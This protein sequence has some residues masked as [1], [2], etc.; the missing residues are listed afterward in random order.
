M[1]E[2]FLKTLKK[3]FYHLKQA[4]CKHFKIISRLN[5]NIYHLIKFLSD[6]I[7]IE[8]FPLMFKPNR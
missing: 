3:K 7:T 4:L 2:K 5:E 1:D 8:K 6:E